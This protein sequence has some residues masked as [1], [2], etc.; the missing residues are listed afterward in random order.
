MGGGVDYIGAKKSKKINHDNEWKKKRD[1]EMGSL[2]IKRVTRLFM[3][4]KNLK[5]SVWML[6]PSKKRVCDT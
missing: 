3:S 1:K 5:I 2:Y 6:S 4:I